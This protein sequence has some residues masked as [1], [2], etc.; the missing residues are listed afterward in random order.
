M[1]LEDDDC[2]TM[3]SNGF[4]RD[5][6]AESSSDSES[7]AESLPASPLVPPIAVLDVPASSPAKSAASATPRRSNLQV[8]VLL[9]PRPSRSSLPRYT[10]PL[11]SAPS[12]PPPFVP[13]SYSSRWATRFPSLSSS[14]D[15]PLSSRIKPS[16]QALGKRRAVRSPSPAPAKRAHTSPSPPR[17][18]GLRSRASKSTSVAPQRS[19]ASTTRKASGL[20][21]PLADRRA[22]AMNKPSV[23]VNPAIGDRTLVLACQALALEPMVCLYLL[24]F[25]YFLIFFLGIS[26]LHHL[27]DLSSFLRVC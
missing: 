4:E 13:N 5:P 1:T 16:A 6:G 19:R 20:K 22:L 7:A 11:V 14:P 18:Y 21:L 15:L 9:S 24:F 27:F 17:P 23:A 8:E 2:P 10:P 12:S 25:D 3:H 26:F